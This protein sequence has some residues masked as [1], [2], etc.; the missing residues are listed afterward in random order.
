LAT[1]SYHHEPPRSR[2]ARTSEHR[3]MMNCGL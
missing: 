2:P 1:D 3:V